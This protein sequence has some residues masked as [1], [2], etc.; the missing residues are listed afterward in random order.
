MS[1]G[2][3]I[4]WHTANN[5]IVV[6]SGTRHKRHILKLL[7]IAINA[8]ENFILIFLVSSAVIYIVA[9]PKPYIGVSI[10]G[11]I[12]I[13]IAHLCLSGIAFS[14]ISNCP[15]TNRLHGARNR[16]SSEMM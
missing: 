5:F 15:D 14:K 7:M 2:I 3:F 11:I 12:Q 13:R 6:I 10:S 9:Q 16:R 1:K 8:I 4:T